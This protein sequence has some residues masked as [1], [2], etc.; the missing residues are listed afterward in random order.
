MCT[1]SGK[2]GSQPPIDWHQDLFLTVDFHVMVNNQDLTV[3]HD[4]ELCFPQLQ[5]LLKVS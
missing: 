5:R 2:T 4:L 1:T 3:A